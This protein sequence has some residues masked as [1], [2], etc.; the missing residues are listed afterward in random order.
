MA[1]YKS[2][3]NLP[4]KMEEQPPYPRRAPTGRLPQRSVTPTTTISQVPAPVPSKLQ[5][6]RPSRDEVLL[7]RGAPGQRVPTPKAAVMLGSRQAGAS[8][9]VPIIHPAP[10]QM[11]PK[12]ALQSSSRLPKPEMPTNTRTPSLVSGSSASTVDSPQ[13][14]LLRRKQTNIG[15]GGSREDGSSVS[16]QEKSIMPSGIPGGYKDPFSETVLGI[17]I[18]STSAVLAHSAAELELQH[19][20]PYEYDLGPTEILPPPAPHYTLST[21]PSTRYSESPGPFS[22]SST[23]TSMSSYSPGVV[24]S[25]KTNTR[26]RQ[27]SPLQGKPPVVRYRTPEEPRM[28]SES[29][30]ER[31]QIER[32]PTRPSDPTSRT[33]HTR[34]P[35][36]HR[37]ADAMKG[38]VSK[39]LRRPSQTMEQ[40]PR[41]QAPPELAHLADQPSSTAAPRR[42][43][44]PS[45][46]G[47]PEITGFRGPSP[48]IQSNMNSFPFSHQRT[49]ST[50]STSSVG[51][52]SKTRFGIMSPKQSSRNPSPNPSLTSSF[53]PTSRV[54]TRGPT[55]DLQPDKKRSSTLPTPAPAPS[56]SKTSRFGFFSR[57]AKTE[58]T[59]PAVKSE[60]KLHRRGP[61]AGTGHEGYGRYAVGAR[62]ASGASG[63]SIGKSLSAATTSESF[64]K[65][66]STRKS[67]VTST[68]STEMD[69]FFLERLNPVVIRGNGSNSELTMSPEP[70]QSTSSLDVSSP[71][72]SQLSKT[73]KG[74]SGTDSEKARPALLPSA[75]SD[76]VQGMSPVKRMPI[77]PRRP[78]ESEDE[79]KKSLIP[80]IAAKRASRSSKFVDTTTSAKQSFS[81]ARKGS[82]TGATS[83]GKEG[84]WL[85]SSKKEKTEQEASKPPR[86]WNFFQR[87]HGAS[88]VP[89][90]AVE[91]PT[92]SAARIPV[93]RSVAHYAIVDSPSGLDA[94]DIEMIM[95]EAD[96]APEEPP[97]PIQQDE[98]PEFNVQPKATER[99]PSM[100]LPPKPILPD[101]FTAPA[102]PASPKVFLRPVPEPQPKLTLDTSVTEQAH[103]VPPSV[104]DLTP[105]TDLSAPSS[106]GSPLS[107]GQPSDLV[108]S[109]NTL[110]APVFLPSPPATLSPP[111][112]PPSNPPPRPSRLAQVG[113]IPQVVST[114]HKAHR[115]H[116]R[117]FSRP[118]AMTQPGPKA[119]SWTSF[120]SI[121][122]MTVTAGPAEPYPILHG[123][124]AL[125]HGTAI[126]TVSPSAV[127]SMRQGEFFVFPSRKGSE[128]SYSSSSGTW[129]F[130]AT[131][132]TAIVPILGAPQSEDEVWNE[133]NDLIDEVLSPTDL[134]NADGGESEEKR[135]ALE[136]LP[137]K[138]KHSRASSHS[139]ASTTR[140]SNPSLHLR[141]SRLLAV[142]HSQSPTSSISLSEFLQEYGDRN[143]SVVDPISGR[144]SFPSTA[145]MSVGSGPRDRVSSNRSSLPAS[146]NLSSRQSKATLASK[147]DRDRNSASS[148]KYRDTRLMEM[149]ETRADGLSAMANLRFGAL[150]TSK[151]LSFGRVIFSPAHF[152]L[153]DP[154]HDR[155]LVIDGLGKDWSYYCALTYPEATVYNLGPGQPSI[156]TTTTGNAPEP[157]STLSNHRHFNQNTLGDPFPFPRGFF[158]CVVLRFPSAV[159]T[160][161]HR[162]VVSECKRVLRPG[163]F[164]ELSVLDLDL[165]NMGNRARRAVRGLKVK[166]QVADEDVSLRNISDE[167]MGLV[168]K[169]GFTE[170]NRCF[171][172]VP[173]AGTLPSP[174]QTD[175]A[176]SKKR[177]GSTASSINKPTGA[178]TKA[179]KKPKPEVSF[180][181]LLNTR[182]SSES[183]DNTITDMVA[184]VGRWWYSRCYESL[185]L[186]EA[187]E[188]D[189]AN[190]GD[191]LRSSI[192][193]DESLINECEKRGTSFRLLI[194]YAQKPIVG[195]RRTVSV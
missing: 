75:M 12:S 87:A 151:W 56:P 2:H 114:R 4:R 34:L 111:G 21:T 166:M 24:M 136:P 121:G 57:R 80:A 68:T 155:I 168:G 51:M 128:V 101:I 175:A 58:P 149:A 32:L 169:K 26:T 65:T 162:T 49:T 167:I 156:T 157:W 163:G 1:T 77:G 103:R 159:P 7:T 152:E 78:S 143:I 43:S 40:K 70:L 13:S 23:P 63:S 41:V 123:L 98:P 59:A 192:W 79:L 29:S 35:T 160:S 93:S 105:V 154:E 137:L 134:Q 74:P 17:S 27:V 81:K 37:Q 42:P 119:S 52:N 39:G 91:A 126:A 22:V 190:S 92:S 165:V 181:D 100:L 90:P 173:V 144:L 28:N 71:R 176:S 85:K 73:T 187:G 20:S 142:L 131:A 189:A 61:A 89:T 3:S 140:V 180:S 6:R 36:S 109:P 170:C 113:R 120:D 69:D 122:P 118:F 164:L 76:S 64:D 184:R 25:T 8:S 150:M 16:F 148:N 18:P 177:K 141:R 117:S 193:R 48:I 179:T 44:R 47:T 110:P 15:V 72:L 116:S 194:G 195:V 14:N 127:E 107:P 106:P 38:D 11:A 66:P 62:S 188:P 55:P 53:A 183:T 9:T 30:N 161:V 132:G 125:T 54:P 182:A 146:L 97:A 46:D 5:K 135:S 10:R 153:K 50:G 115:P 129:S 139:A 31:S 67:S 191:L 104:G 145:H 102:R 108:V 138:L 19:R 172:G 186:P 45:R 33:T 147:S 94:N 174:D 171:V 60:K 88:R 133:Y 96:S 99:L 83:D 82:L 130:P 86:K 112:P 84:G 185:V 124:N 95:K 178:A 158:A